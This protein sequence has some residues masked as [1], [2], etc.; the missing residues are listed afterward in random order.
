MG[1]GRSVWFLLALAASACAEAPEPRSREN[2][3][4]GGGGGGGVELDVTSALQCGGQDP[5]GV[6]TLDRGHSCSLSGILLY[7]LSLA[8]SLSLN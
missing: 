2:A 3:R 6:P 8:L 1:S 5:R 4:A 7:S